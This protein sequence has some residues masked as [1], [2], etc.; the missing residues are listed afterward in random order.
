[1]SEEIKN[2]L[3]SIAEAYPWITDAT[4]EEAFALQSRHNLQ[5]RKVLSTLAGTDTS[6]D[7]IVDAVM[8]GTDGA[9]FKTFTQEVRSGL[10]GVLKSFEREQDA[11]AIAEL[12]YDLSKGLYGI[13]YG[14]SEIENQVDSPIA[15]GGRRGAI[16]KV[17]KKSVD[18]FLENG[19]VAAEALVYATASTAFGLKLMQ[20]QEK[21]IRAMIDYGIVASDLKVYN[22]I[23]DQTAG[24]GMSVNS[25]LKEIGS[26]SN[27]FANMSNDV[28]GGVLEF[29]KFGETLMSDNTFS[30]LGYSATKFAEQLANETELLRRMQEIDVLNAEAREKIAESFTR[31]NVFALNMANSTGESR[32]ELLNARSDTLGDPELIVAMDKNMAH[33]INQLGDD[34]PANIREAIG[35]L[36][37]LTQTLPPDFKAMTMDTLVR[38]VYDFNLD[39]DPINNMSLELNEQLTLMGSE[40]KVQFNEILKNVVQGAY[41]ANNPEQL[42][43][44]YV[45]F[46]KLVRDSDVLDV[47]RLTITE[48]QLAVREMQDL[49]TTYPQS[50]F[51]MEKT[52]RMFTEQQVK[53]A[54]EISASVVNAVNNVAVFMT[55]MR[56]NILPE[57]TTMATA[58]RS[59]DQMLDTVATGANALA[60]VLGI[61]PEPAPP[62]PFDEAVNSVT[63][64]HQEFVQNM[65]TAIA[66]TSQQQREMNAVLPHQGGGNID[67]L[68]NGSSQTIDENLIVQQ[69]SDVVA[70]RVTAALKEQ[71]ITDPVAI[72]N[73]L[74]MVSG[75]SGFKLKTEQSYR[76][77]SVA[78][79]MEVLGNRAKYFTPQELEILKKD[80]EAF[81]NAM[82]GEEQALRRAAAGVSTQGADLG[83][84]KYRGRGYIQITGRENYKKIGEH[85]GIDLLN[86]P[87]L[88]LDPYW[89][90]KIT[91]AYYSTMSA[92]NQRS[93][94]NAVDVYRLTYGA[95][96]T[97]ARL[98]DF[99]KRNRV[100]RKFLANR[101]S[102]SEID[103]SLTE[104]EQIFSMTNQ[105]LSREADSARNDLYDPRI[106]GRLTESERERLEYIIALDENR[107]AQPVDPEST[108][109]LPTLDEVQDDT[110]NTNETNS[111]P[112]TENRNADEAIRNELDHQVEENR[113][114]NRQSETIR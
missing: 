86:N 105:E 109:I 85:L 59:F 57:Y 25:F 82:Y 74:G 90:P 39:F 58:I 16:G 70:A 55:E 68:L 110:I 30:K 23:R 92:R 45:N 77:T 26:F 11:L 37:M 33:I 47:R 89:A 62:S 50:Y 31:T 60:D 93:L 102:L 21:S 38:T 27:T 108:P 81:F 41:D 95:R 14:L 78:R 10:N 6:F 46:L 111:D 101:N 64:A 99:R 88:A 44:D 54:M 48:N 73:I 112:I 28:A 2:Y 83:G 94:S 69:S 100:A 9:F 8:E 13:A 32:D 22:I 20:E 17:I 113:S 72:A 107:N 103:T 7:D 63:Q 36:S 42:T 97:G 43:A 96:P 75:E 19:V 71:G 98:S 15:G 87:D 51:E 29:S 91:A 34:A 53:S 35:H 52:H 106:R 104:K 79:I 40:V 1:M 5:A 66:P 4:M 61:E 114:T 80:D 76:N 24:M 49:I 12:S 18:F 65:N 56:A 84:Y 67:H 3:Q